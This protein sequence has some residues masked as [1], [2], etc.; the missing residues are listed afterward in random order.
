MSIALR[1]IDEPSYDEA[2]AEAFSERFVTA[3]SE[4][5]LMMMFSIGHRTGLFDTMDGM[6]W[7]TPP[8]RSPTGPG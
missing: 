1:T 6:D 3:L 2:K 5:S 7:S 8:S 4:S